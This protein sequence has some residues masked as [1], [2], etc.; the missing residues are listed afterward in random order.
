MP[1]NQDKIREMQALEQTIQN[2]ALQK[3]AFEMELSETKSAL[4][5]IEKSGDEIFKIM[6]QLMI[7]T[8]KEKTKRE[9]SEKERILNVR[10]KTMEKQEISHSAKLDETRNEFMRQR[11]RGK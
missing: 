6:G 5:E 2:L 4:N 3:Q 11:Q 10:I 8:E 7:K 9:L 1:E